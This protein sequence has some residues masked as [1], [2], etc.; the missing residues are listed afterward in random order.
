MFLQSNVKDDH[1]T[2]SISTPATT[3]G[4]KQNFFFQSFLNK[5]VLPYFSFKSTFGL[6]KYTYTGTYINI[7][8][9]KYYALGQTE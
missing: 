5:N 7:I 8:H 3:S 9:K 6:S 2:G 4:M 1:K